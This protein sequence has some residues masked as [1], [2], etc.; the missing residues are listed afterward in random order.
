MPNYINPAK[1]DVISIV[2]ML[3]ND[4]RPYYNHNKVDLL[5]NI[6][7]EKSFNASFFS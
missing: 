6:A 3:T 7:L 5:H 1:I 2:V 4:E